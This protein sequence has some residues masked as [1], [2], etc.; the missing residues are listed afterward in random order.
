VGRE[1]RSAAILCLGTD[2]EV[3][4]AGGTRSRAATKVVVGMATGCWRPDGRL[5]WAIEGSK[6]SLVRGVGVDPKAFLC[7]LKAATARAVAEKAPILAICT[8]CQEPVDPELL[9][10]TGTCIDCADPRATSVATDRYL[11][12]T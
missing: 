2:A 12:A 1:G 10:H 3:I 9:A 5:G 8:T 4:G 6:S 11:V 7:A